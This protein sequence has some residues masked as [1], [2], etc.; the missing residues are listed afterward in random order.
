VRYFG[1]LQGPVRL[2]DGSGSIE[3]RDL[4]VMFQKI[5]YDGLAGDAFLS[6]F[7]V[8]FDL[9]RSEMIFAPRL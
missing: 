5:I 7:T 3:A 9:P 4:P 6:R 2:A 8:S 1:R